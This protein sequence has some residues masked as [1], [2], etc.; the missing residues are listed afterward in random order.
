MTAAHGKEIEANAPHGTRKAYKAS[1]GNFHAAASYAAKMAKTQGVEMA[2]IPGNSY[3]S[4]VF[5]I[6]RIDGDL[7]FYISGFPSVVGAT[8][9]PEGLVRMAELSTK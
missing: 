5:H 2:L 4:A 9:T 6:A 7:G 8:V 1:P 3:G